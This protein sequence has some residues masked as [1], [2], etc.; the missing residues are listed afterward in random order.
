MITR[1]SSIRFAADVPSEQDA[2]N[3]CR[4]F[5][6]RPIFVADQEWICHHIAFGLDTDERY[7]FSISLT[8][9]PHSCAC[10]RCGRKGK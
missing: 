10:G 5:L 3:L 4:L 7:V 1:A 2:Q 9:K 8:P 6:G